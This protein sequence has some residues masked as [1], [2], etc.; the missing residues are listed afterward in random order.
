MVFI[1]V[2]AGLIS[3]LACD[4]NESKTRERSLIGENRSFALSNSR[5]NSPVRKVRC[6]P[7]RRNVYRGRMISIHSD[8]NVIANGIV[9]H[10]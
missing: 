9:R 2:N 1:K 6:E 8:D 7:V 5:D 3:F 4:T 10:A